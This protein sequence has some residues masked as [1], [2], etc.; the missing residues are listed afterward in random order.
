MQKSNFCH[1][2]LPSLDN[3]LWRD[4][5]KSSN[6]ETIL[7]AFILTKIIDLGIEGRLGLDD[8]VQ[9]TVILLQWGNPVLKYPGG[10]TGLHW[11]AGLGKRQGLQGL[12]RWVKQ[13]RDALKPRVSGEMD[14][15]GLVFGCREA[16][17]EQEV[18]WALERKS[19]GEQRQDLWQPL[20]VSQGVGAVHRR[21]HHEEDIRRGDASLNNGQSDILEAKGVTA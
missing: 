13:V 7:M 19:R 20:T 17:Q 18:V 15:V 9:A 10:L 21:R 12:M 11:Q 16:W 14:P 3:K 5:L 2:F 6:D 4:A 8:L 1:S